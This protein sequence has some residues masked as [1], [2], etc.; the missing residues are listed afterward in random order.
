MLDTLYAQK[1][2][3]NPKLPAGISV[4]D[5]KKSKTVY[6]VTTSNFIL[7]DVIPRVLTGNIF[8]YSINPE[9][10]DL[11][12]LLQSPDV[13]FIQPER[14]AT[15]EMVINGSDLSLNNIFFAHSKYTVNGEGLTVSVKENRPD[16][17]DIDFYKRF[18]R[19]G[20][21]SSTLSAHATAMAT[22]VGG[23]GNTYY[24]GKGA[25]YKV[26]VSS[27]SFQT[28]LPEHDTVYK[29]HNISIQNHSYGTM[30][31]NFYGV[32]ALAYDVSVANNDSLLHVFSAGNSGN[33]TSTAGKYMG[34]TGFANLTGS[35]K[36]SK[37][38]LSV[39]ATDS[40][41]NIEALSSKGPAYDGR[42]KPELVAFG[43]DGS[44][45]AAALVSGSAILLQHAYKQ[46]KGKLP[47]SS[48]MR[49]ALINAANDVSA[50]GP[51]F[52]SGFGS[53]NTER[54]LK[55]IINNQYFT[56]S[57]NNGNSI[58]FNIV[59]PANSTEL[60]IT[61][62]WNDVPATVNAS[63]ALVNDLDLEVIEVNSGNVFFPY[64]LSSFPHPDSLNGIAVR[65]KDT[66][67]NIEQVMIDLPSASNYIIRVKGSSV[68]GSQQFAVVFNSEIKNS[69]EFTYPTKNNNLFPGNVNTIRWNSF[70][71]ATTNG[72]LEITYDGTNWLTLSPATQLLNKYYKANIKDTIAV[73]RLRM[74]FGTSVILSDSFTVSPRLQTNVGYHCADSFQ[75]YWNKLKGASGYSI[76]ALAD[77]FM[78]PLYQTTDSTITLPVTN[79]RHFAVAPTINSQTGDRSFAF[80]YTTQGVGCFIN[81]FLADVF[82][83]TTVQL[84]AVLGT[85]QNIKELSFQRLYPLTTLATFTVNRD[86]FTTS[87][88]LSKNGIYY[89]RVKLI[90]HNGKEIISD[91]L[92]VRIFQDEQFIVYPNPYRNGGHLIIQSKDHDNSIFELFSV[93]GQKVYSKKLTNDTEK[94]SLPVLQSGIYF[95]RIIQ[96]NKRVLNGK[97][98]VN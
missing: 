30:I 61:L 6:L 45:G 38:T 11:S 70:N 51:D 73:A 16:T 87:D 8:L 57:I 15:E 91:T 86:T 44:S 19:T 39:A 5:L 46:S 88:K 64:V 20:L 37:N 1:N 98:M 83:D 27:A 97:L 58:D 4:Y 29:K 53:L 66:L 55:Q 81:V 71:D 67:N 82:N 90:M 10:T 65:R 50:Q 48:L 89:Y 52:K 2:G 49:A 75:L 28:L 3:T 80:N 35:F 47:A 9:E 26:N 7:R 54:A 23:A 62:A 69:F 60:K 33:L 79:L 84:Q 22:L 13:L 43:Q 72:K 12:M 41:N 68:Q 18:K 17:L 56:A 36:Q 21:E 77:T 59:V 31:E 32:D 78:K 42:L 95:Y 94:L 63:K 14:K 25:A 92:Q 85:R 76:Y 93:A 40:M 96:Q 74:S 34:I 24:T